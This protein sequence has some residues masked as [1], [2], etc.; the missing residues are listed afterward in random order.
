MNFTLHQTDTQTKARAGSLQTG[1]GVIETPIFMP[2]GTQSTVKNVSQQQLKNDV[3]AQII[4]ANT[5]H[6]YLRPGLEVIGKAGG[7]HIGTSPC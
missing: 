3:N 6:T 1:R 4:L 7:I 2:V 5:Y